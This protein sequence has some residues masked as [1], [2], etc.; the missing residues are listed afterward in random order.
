MRKKRILL[1]TIM[2]SGLFLSSCKKTDNE[3][4]I[5]ENVYYSKNNINCSSLNENVQSTFLSENAVYTLQ[6][7]SME[8]DNTFMTLNDDK[9]LNLDIDV[10]NVKSIQSKVSLYMNERK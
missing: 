9:L 8:Y 2:V 1:I 10:V 3:K 4:I 6:T 7:N 5:N